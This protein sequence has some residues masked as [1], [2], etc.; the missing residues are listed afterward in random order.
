MTMNVSLIELNGK[1]NSSKNAVIS[2]LT[3]TW[4]LTAKE[5]YN[6][7]K[8]KFGLNI[9]YQAIHKTIKILEEGQILTKENDGYRLNEDWIDKTRDFSEHLSMTYKLFQKF[10][11]QIT[12]PTL[13][14]ADK[15]LLNM[16]LKMLPK[17]GER[18]FLGLHWNHFWIPLF[19]SIKEYNQIKET[20][21]KFDVYALSRGNNKVDNWC[22]DF[23][24]KN[25]MK[26]KTG[27]DCAGIADLV[28]HKD[29]VVEVFY[30]ADIKQELD[31]FYNETDSISDID[32][33][34][35]FDNIFQKK[36]KIN[37]V[38]HKNQVLA[39]QLKEQTLEY[40]EGDKK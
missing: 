3:E 16:M 22:A 24:S 15:F 12:M 33:T 20:F 31:K 26:A 32:T 11:P 13:Y 2:V 38:V 18:P 40:F 34:H 23:W 7:T 8:I 5:I 9:S 1:I 4:P 27:I 36:T 19:M 21:P 6:E 10:G 14:D 37:I 17:N 35:V 29:M 28:I 39:D 25:S 30:P